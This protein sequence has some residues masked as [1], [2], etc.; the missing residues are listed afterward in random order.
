MVWAFCTSARLSIRLFPIEP[1]GGTL[2]IVGR[3]RDVTRPSAKLFEPA[4]VGKLTLRNRLVRS[5]TWEGLAT[6]EGG[7]TDRLAGLLADLVLGGVGLIISGYTYISPEGKGL[8]GMTGLYSDKLIP[9]FMRLTSE[10][11]QLGGAVAVQLVHTGGRADPRYIGNYKPI[12]P[13]AIE[14]P[15]YPG[16]PHEMSIADIE[17]VI[18]AFSRAAGRAKRAGY[19]AVQIH[20]AHG[21]L[22]NQ[23]LSPSTNRRSDEYGGSLQNRA[24]FLIEVYR[25]VREE[26]GKEFP[27]MIKINGEDFYHGGVTIREAIY[28]VHKLVSL[29]LDVVEVSGGTPASGKQGP[30]RTGIRSMRQ[31]AYFLSQ[32]KAIRGSVT[33][34]LVLVGG[35]RSYE[36]VTELL[37]QRHVD[38][39]AMSRPLIREP[40]L[41]NRWREGDRQRA[42]CISCNLCFDTALQ[43]GLACGY[44]RELAARGVAL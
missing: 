35:L 25:R 37:A 3:T 22:I 30:S 27:V 9:G 43:D 8:S 15:M 18:E 34:P 41:A 31:E 20:A 13:S 23:F 7:V 14:H 12:A 42:K 21:F 5:A 26:V 39:I 10:I 6:D 24:R 33:I 29:G 16:R 36:C 32:T 11:H 2:S 17:E 28:F 38:L 1:L 44:E 40:N 19:D 4:H